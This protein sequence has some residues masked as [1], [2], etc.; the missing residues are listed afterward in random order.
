[1]SVNITYISDTTRKVQKIEPV[2]SIPKIYNNNTQNQG[3][4]SKKNEHS[5][6]FKEM[7]DSQIEDSE[8]GFQKRK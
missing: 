3:S 2:S 7:F 6:T 8:K 5:S 1:V 4:G